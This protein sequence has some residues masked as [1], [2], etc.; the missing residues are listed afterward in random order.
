MGLIK[1]GQ[2]YMRLILFFI[3]T[4]TFAQNHTAVVYTRT[5]PGI[6]SSL[7]IGGIWFGVG[8]L[9]TT[10]GFVL[11]YRHW[12]KSVTEPYPSKN[13]LSENPMLSLM[14]A[15]ATPIAS[16]SYD[17]WLSNFV[18]AY[19]AWRFNPTDIEVLKVPPKPVSCGI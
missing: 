11:A 19:S 17:Q 13:T 16:Y 14:A 15:L 6:G 10:P 8:L 18:T 1:A 3:A 2:V 7:E 9:F 12:S 4:M 5:T